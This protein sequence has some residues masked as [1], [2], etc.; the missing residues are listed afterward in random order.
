MSKNHDPIKTIQYACQLLS[1]GKNDK[2]ALLIASDYPFEPKSNAGR[3]YSISEQTQIYV[4]DGFI[5]R[6]TGKRLIYT[7][8]LRLLSYFFPKEFPYHLNWKATACHTA[9]WD[10][11]PTLDHIIPVSQGGA[12]SKENLVTCSMLTNSKKSNWSMGQVGFSLVPRGNLAEW[13]GMVSWFMQQIANTPGLDQES[14]LRKWY[15]AAK[16]IQWVNEG[17]LDEP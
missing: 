2:A 16:K 6:Y 8:A 12:S 4:R 5:D 10:L 3:K 11:T 7:P 1:E 14:G 9:Y 17:M 15:I 13:D